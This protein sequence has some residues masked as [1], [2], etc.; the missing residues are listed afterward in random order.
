MF[1]YIY[2]LISINRKILYNIFINF[3]NFT[4][5]ILKLL[6]SNILQ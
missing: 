4:I 1:N 2:N 5:I 3:F 6:K